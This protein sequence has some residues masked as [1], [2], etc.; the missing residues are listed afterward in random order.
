M[1]VIRQNLEVSF[2]G[3]G[4][5]PLRSGKSPG[6]LYLAPVLLIAA[7]IVGILLSFQSNDLNYQLQIVGLGLALGC[8]GLALLLWERSV[9]VGVIR[10]E[11]HSPSLRFSYAPSLDLLYPFAAVLI[12]LPAIL[13]LFALLRSEAAEEIGFGRRTV[14]VLGILGFVLFVQQ[15]WVLRVP[16]GLEL[17]SEGVRGVRGAGRIVLNWDNLG[18]ASAMSTRT[19]AKLGLQVK[20]GE[21]HI[22]PRRL[23]GSDP[24][25]VAAIINYYLRHPADRDHLATP[26]FAIQLVAQD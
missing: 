1:S 16:R 12:M 3:I 25:T 26:E 19:G 5:T 9:S 14:Y 10:V 22:L 7:M 23:I 6:Q 21:V 24:D 13:A 4:E 18:A 2:P 15:L 11:N 8:L 20:S 17:T